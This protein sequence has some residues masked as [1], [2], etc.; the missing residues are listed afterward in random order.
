MTSLTLVRRF[1]VRFR[2]LD[3]TEHESSGEFL[4]IIQPERNVS[5]VP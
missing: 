3:N 1:R 4:E 5:A 2:L